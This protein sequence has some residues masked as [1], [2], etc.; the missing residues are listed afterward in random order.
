MSYLSSR[1]RRLALATVVLASDALGEEAAPEQPPEPEQPAPTYEARVVASRPF[2]AATASIIRDRD[3]LAMP[4]HTPT[5]LLRSV[6]GLVIAQHQGGGKADQLFLR[7]FDADHG[8]DV[9]LSID[10]VPINLVGHA[11]GHG[12]VDLHFLIPEVIERLEVTK[13]PYFADQGDFAT[14]G[15]V[16]L[17]TRSALERPQVSLSA[18][19]FDTYRLLAQASHSTGR[20]SSFAAIEG[21]VSDGPFLS[22]ERLRRFNLFAKASHELSNTTRLALLITSHASTWNGSGQIPAR[23]VDAGLLDRFG[24]LDPSEG[25]ETQ[26]HQ[27]TAAF[28]HDAG[29]GRFTATLSLLRYGL[30]LFNNFTFNLNDPVHGDAIEQDD[31]RTML[32]GAAR[33]ERLTSTRW[34]NLKHLVGVSGR[35]DDIEGALWQVQARRRLLDCRGGQNPCVHT[36]TRQSNDALFLQEEWH[37]LRG[38]RIIAGGRLDRLAARVESLRP[39]G[40]LSVGASLQLPARLDR[41]LLSPKLSAV[42][43]P[44]PTVD[45]FVN[46]GRGFHSNDV[47]SALSS[48]GTGL[49]GLA[50]GAEAGARAVFL[51][52][53]LEL[54]A[55]LWGIDLTSELVWSG[56]EGTTE[57][58]DATRRLGVE[59]EIRWRPLSWLAADAS[60]TA[61]QAR[62]AKGG[63]G[64]A[65]PLAPTLVI[66]GGVMARHP[67]GVGGA[68][69]IRHLAD[70]PATEWTAA[71]GVPRCTGALDAG[72][73]AMACFLVAEG[74]TVADLQLTYETRR[75]SLAL[76]VENL[77]NAVYREAQFGSDS[78]VDL[79]GLLS[80]RHPVRDVHFTPGNPLSLLLTVTAKL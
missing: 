18:G 79:P 66:T 49:F 36:R 38:V 6:P 1:A 45:L 30:A 76:T 17:V 23:L 40:R 74:Y 47:R 65:V 15:A 71:D 61:A 33:Y 22:P 5:D 59:A 7:G 4:R 43:S 50:T 42:V 8:T 39:D 29:D 75:W 44:H 72:D 51:D 19:T 52:R 3:F 28:V 24:A 53:T 69:R 14:A 31:S 64:S 21:H 12:Y 20:T 48:E 60:L 54:S 55:A 62:Y 26:R 2:T 78:R 67:S 32:F 46:A 80:E 57:P 56:D 63:P 11:H 27:A 77:T 34:G 35:F 9:A 37:P 13:G 41:L 58:S 16:N 73:P 10:G 68:V 70:R 25:G